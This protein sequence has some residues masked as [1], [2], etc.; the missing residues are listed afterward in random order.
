VDR[1]VERA[2]VGHRNGD[3]DL[4]LERFRI[5]H[6]VRRRSVRR[7][8][9]PVELQL[10]VLRQDATSGR[11]STRA[12]AAPLDPFL[13]PEGRVLATLEEDGRRRWI[14]PKLSPGGWWHLRRAVAWALIVIFAL[15]PWTTYDGLP[16]VLLDVVDRKFVFFGAVFRPTETLLF[17]LGFIAIFVGV[18]LMTALFG[19]VWCGWACPQTVYME[20]VYR[21]LERLF[22]GKGAM[23]AKAAVATWRRVA[24]YAAYLL[25]SAHLANTFLAW[26]IGAERLNDWILA[27]TPSA[28]PVAFAI[29]AAITLLMLFDF[30]FFREQMCSLVCP[31]G[32][33][34][35]A[36]L[37]R[38]SLVVGYDRGRG[39]PRGRAKAPRAESGKGGC[40]GGCGC[41]AK[42]GCGSG[43]RCDGHGGDAAHGV[44]AERA[45]ATATAI[46]GRR[47][48]CIDCT[49]CV[50]TCPAGIDIRDGL[51]LECIQCTQ[52]IDA[53]DAVMSKLGKPVGLIRYSSQRVLSGEPRKGIRAR[54]VVYPTLLAIALAGIAWLLATREPAA[55]AVIRAQGIPYAE[56]DG[57]IESVVRLRIDN[58]MREARTYVVEGAEGVILAQSARIEVAGDASGETD[59]VVVS[60]PQEFERGRREVEL[61]V[62]DESGAWTGVLRTHALGPLVLAPIAGGKA[63]RP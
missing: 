49:L 39:E 1:T 14:R 59:V 40:G 43:D 57:R 60:R 21:P 6:R 19:R 26:F 35:S 27:S 23:Q 54:L 18:F 50:Q 62:R 36:L 41:D 17:A 37:D 52:C 7:H 61:V 10:P 30:A 5:V 48:D 8:P 63:G 25:V 22:L 34:Q 45:T 32:R 53:C 9:M 12:S 11:T 33:F 13:R 58:R 29:F 20:F 51:Q 3:L 24:M 46:D 47:G 38:D 31:Y 55:L 56:H 28:H 42:G 44:Q 15:V 4:D 2:C 16:T